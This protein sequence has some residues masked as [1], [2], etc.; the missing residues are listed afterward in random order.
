MDIEHKELG[1]VTLSMNIFTEKLQ[2][3]FDLKDNVADYK[4][5][6]EQIKR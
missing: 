1:Q 5:Q 3:A 2:Q 6:V 4:H